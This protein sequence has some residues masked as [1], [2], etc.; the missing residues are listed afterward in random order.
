MIQ[1][2]QKDRIDCLQATKVH[3]SRNSRTF[4]LSCV[5]WNDVKQV[6][7]RFVVAVCG[8]LRR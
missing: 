5:E 8:V 2:R 1:T 3:C 4:V 7:T 6:Q